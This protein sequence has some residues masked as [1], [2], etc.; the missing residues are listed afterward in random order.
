MPG[1][2]RVPS[3]GSAMFDGAVAAAPPA[4]D[5]VSGELE[6][7]PAAAAPSTVTPG[8]GHP[9]DSGCWLFHNRSSCVARFCVCVNVALV[10]AERWFLC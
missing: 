5:A 9:D 8:A 6:F 4:A 10:T 2:L 7:P 3:T 1:L